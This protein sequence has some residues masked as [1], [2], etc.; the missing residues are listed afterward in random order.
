[1]KHPP[2][3]PKWPQ[4]KRSKAHKEAS[5][6]LTSTWTTIPAE[7][8][9]KLQD[10]KPE[11]PEL[12]DLLKTHIDCEQAHQF[13][14]KHG[15]SPSHQ[16]QDPSAGKPP[17]KENWTARKRSSKACSRTCKS[18]R[19]RSLKAKA[20]SRPSDDYMKAANQ[21]PAPK[22]LNESAMEVDHLSAEVEAF[23]TSLEPAPRALEK[24][25]P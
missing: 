9:T 10:S 16:A 24:A 12:T 5:E 4:L 7:V 22:E 21:T 15:K 3:L 14:A 6:F 11:E 8:Q 2:G 18:F 1:M 19:P 20:P 23:V 25:K 13:R 17:F